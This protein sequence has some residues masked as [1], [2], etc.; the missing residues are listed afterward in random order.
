MVNNTH[1]W[2]KVKSQ[3][4]TY[5]ELREAWASMMI[6][7]LGAFPWSWWVTLTTKKPFPIEI[8]RKRLYRWL[9]TLRKALHGHFEVIWVL[10]R[11][12][13]GAL[14]VHAVISDI[15]ENNKGIWKA[16]INTWE[17][18]NRSGS[19]IGSAQIMRYDPG[20]AGELSNYLA[21]ERCK[22]LDVLEGNGSIFEKLGFSRGVRKYLNTSLNLRKLL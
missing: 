22:D 7:M 13:R 21:K 10:E 11:Q 2:R 1:D 3:K 5:G 6:E 18:P 8:I 4:P 12:R 20:K 16:M 14:H 15:P 17:Y 9:K 19:K